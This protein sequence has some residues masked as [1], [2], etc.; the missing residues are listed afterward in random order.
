MRKEIRLPPSYFEGIKAR[1]E[2]KSKMSVPYGYMTADWAWF[3]GGFNDCDLGL[4]QTI[5]SEGEA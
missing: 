5:E 4:A 3:L 1:E 2:G